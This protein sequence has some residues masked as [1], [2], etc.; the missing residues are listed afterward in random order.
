VI[1]AAL[2]AGWI[3][4]AT[5]GCETH[6]RGDILAGQVLPGVIEKLGD[7][8]VVRCPERVRIERELTRFQCEVAV[9]ADRIAIAVTLDR[10][11][12]FSWRTAP[13]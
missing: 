8:A 13:R 4:M 5:S 2:A 11:G 7:G 1:R 3:G 6:A 9:G 12:R 10:E